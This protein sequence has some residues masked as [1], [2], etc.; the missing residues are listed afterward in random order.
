M[1][2]EVYHFPHYKIDSEI[3][4]STIQVPAKP[5][6]ANVRYGLHSE[7]GT[8][9]FCSPSSRYECDAREFYIHVVLVILAVLGLPCRSGFSPGVASR[10][11]CLVA[12]CGFLIVVA[13]PVAEHGL[14]GFWGSVVGA[15]GLSTCSSL[16]LEHR[17]HSCGAWA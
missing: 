1:D 17:L 10:G 6:S 3:S 7:C 15:H 12:V 13:S 16:A 2:C 8:S 4:H 5:I 11:C 9:D 14:W